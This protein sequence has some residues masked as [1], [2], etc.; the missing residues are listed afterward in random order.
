MHREVEQLARD[1][2]PPQGGAPAV[3]AGVAASAAAGGRAAGSSQVARCWHFDSVAAKIPTPSHA[4]TRSFVR[5][6]GRAWVGWQRRH[7]LA[8]TGGLDLESGLAD[9][10]G[11]AQEDGVVIGQRHM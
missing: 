4:S 8:P 10:D 7:D 11:L 9:Q 6:S 5:L 1:L 3:S 2:T